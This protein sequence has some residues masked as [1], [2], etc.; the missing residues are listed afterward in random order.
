VRVSVVRRLSIRARVTLAFSVVIAVVLAGIGLFVY[1]RLGATLRQS[2]DR[3]LNGR[4]DDIAVVLRQ[5]PPR[6][7]ARVAGSL[8]DR[9]R[10]LAQILDGSGRVVDGTPSLGRRPLLSVRELGRARRGPVRVSHPTPRFDGDGVRVYARPVRA[11][12]RSYVVVVATA[13][14]PSEDAQHDLGGLLLLGGP[15]ALALAAL[16]GY[17]AT[18]ASLAPVER[19]RSRAAAIGAHSDERLPVPPTEDEVA[20][21]GQTLNEMLERLH[22]AYEHERSFVDDA[23]HELR[24]PLSILKGELEL[25]LRDAWTLEAARHAITSAAEETDRLVALAEDLLVIARAD[26]GQLPIR[27]VMIDAAELLRAAADRFASRARGTGAQVRV[28]APAGVALRGDER[29]LGRALDGLLDNA[30]HHG[31]PGF[32]ATAREERGATVLAVRDHGEGFGPQ[33]AGRAFERFSRDDSARGR[34]GTGLGLAI[35]A[36]IAEAHGGTAFA[37][38]HPEGGAEVGLRLSSGSHPAPGD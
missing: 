30:L 2:V 1:L 26:Q 8:L 24:T 17:G 6:S 15:V 18:A 14:E 7:S 32:A 20:R 12:G 23:S 5:G 27:P 4:A 35:V 31:A 29:L 16:A 19:M 9:P 13:L 36:A 3:T 21:L 33:I 34:G 11:G 22:A 25:A 10:D 28:E 37:L 38:N